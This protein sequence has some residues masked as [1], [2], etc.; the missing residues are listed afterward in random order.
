MPH[1]FFRSSSLQLIRPSSP[2]RPEGVGESRQE[3]P[4]PP[5]HRS[6]S[7]SASGPRTAG[8]RSCTASTSPSAGC[9]RR[10]AGCERGGRSRRPSGGG[11]TAAAHDRQGLR[12]RPRRHWRLVPRPGA[13]RRGCTIP[14]GRGVFPNL[15]VRENLWMATQV[16]RSPGQPRRACAP[17]SHCSGNAAPSWPDRSRAASSRCWRCRGHSSPILRCSCCGRAVDGAGADRRPA[18]LRD[19]G[20]GGAGGSRSWWS[21]S[22]PVPCSASPTGRPSWSTVS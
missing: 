1:G 2:R 16:S 3:R 11:G 21:S 17:G 13:H 19:R 6:W 8:S 10:T 9:G 4:G 15:T 20:A 5:T 18:A 7:S 14:E 12:G 22:S